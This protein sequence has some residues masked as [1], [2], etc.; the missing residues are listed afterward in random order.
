MV[1]NSINQSINQIVVEEHA[2][3]EINKMLKK[4]YIHL[5]ITFENNN[6]NL[7]TV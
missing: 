2:E 5:Y 3:R 1:F 7:I 6:Q 4:K